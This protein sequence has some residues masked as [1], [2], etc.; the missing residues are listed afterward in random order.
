MTIRL[1][2]DTTANWEAADPTLAAGEPGWDLTTKRLR[3][4]DGSTAWTD[5][6]D[7]A[8]ETEITLDGVPD[9][10][11][12]AGSTLTRGLIDLASDVTGNLAWSSVSSKPTTLAGYGITDGLAT[13]GDAA[14]LASGAATDGQVLTADGSGGAAWEAIPG[15]GTDLE[16]HIGVNLAALH[17]SAD[18]RDALDGAAESLGAGNPVASLED[19]AAVSDALSIDE[20][21][22]ATLS[23]GVLTLDLA[24]KRETYHQVALTADVVDVVLDNVPS[25]GPVLVYLRATQATPS[26]TLY[27]IPI[28][29]W[30]GVGATARR[31][32]TPYAITQDADP[33]NI[34]L[35]SLDGMA[36][37]DLRVDSVLEAVPELTIN[38]NTTLAWGTHG[39]RRL[40]CT[41][42]VTLTVNASTD[43]DL[44]DSNWIEIDPYGGDVT[45]AESSATVKS[46]GNK[47]TITQDGG[48]ILTG[49]GSDIYTLVGTLE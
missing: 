22:T 31:W 21:Y 18:E 4:G 46:V 24:N 34:S 37:V 7:Y 25:S 16:D 27:D 45:I 2:Q 41:A 10:L 13:G 28:T 44:A 19:V 35:L 43:L 20:T 32:L 40:I 12:L 9:Y 29:A 33:T 1:R 38:T 17:L 26:G 47:R 48:A 5:L 36:R 8:F 11:T 14:D 23:E 3:I 39:G 15:I 49:R 30:A 6:P 42:A